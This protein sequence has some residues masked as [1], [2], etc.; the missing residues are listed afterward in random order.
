MSNSTLNNKIN[1]FVKHTTEN[2]REAETVGNPHLVLNN[3]DT[4]SQDDFS[5]FD[6]S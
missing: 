5:E 4:S 3:K 2:K 1:S 6:E